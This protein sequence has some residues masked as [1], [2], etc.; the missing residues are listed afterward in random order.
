MGC[1]CGRNK[2]VMPNRSGNIIRNPVVI[3][4]NVVRSSG[5]NNNPPANPNAPVGMN[6]DR[7]EIERKR[8]EA[9]KKSLGKMI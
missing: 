6:K 3:N 7:L 9:I 5:N 2:G 1:G 4:Q 8:R